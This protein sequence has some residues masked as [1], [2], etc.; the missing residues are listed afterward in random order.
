MG[1]RWR[2]PRCESLRLQFPETSPDYLIEELIGEGGM[3]QVYPR[4]ANFPRSAR[5]HQDDACQQYGRRQGR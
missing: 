1:L 2:C 3:G 5:R 4:P